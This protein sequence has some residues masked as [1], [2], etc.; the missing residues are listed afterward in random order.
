MPAIDNL[1]KIFKNEMRSK[2]TCHVYW[3]EKKVVSED[4]VVHIVLGSCVSVVLCG[5]DTGN[6]FWMGVNHMFKSREK[7]DD[8]AL[9]HVAEL[10]NSL[11]EKGV[12]K[13][14]CLGVFGAAYRENSPAKEMAKK[15]V[16]QILEALNLYN[17]TIEVYQTGYSQGVSILKSDSQNSVLIK[18]FN[19]KKRDTNIIEVPLILLFPGDYVS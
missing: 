3:H 18:N 17:L 1:E 16:I 15:N 8:M 14:S 5:K 7:N 6:R 11:E 10:Y 9:H 13:I 12:S 4:H 19:I 2:E